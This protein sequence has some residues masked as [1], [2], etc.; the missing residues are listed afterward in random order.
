MLNIF[1]NFEQ[2]YHIRI[3]FYTTFV[4]FEHSPIKFA[5]IKQISITF[6]Y[7]VLNAILA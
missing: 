6:A 2:I 1:F 5:K 4:H 7:F 3:T